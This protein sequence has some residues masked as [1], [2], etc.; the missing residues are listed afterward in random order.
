MRTIWYM[1]AK[2]RLAGDIQTALRRAAPAAESALDLMSGTGVVSQALAARG[3]LRV[4]ANDVQR[5]A[6]AI[7]RAHL[8]HP[9]DP[10][11]VADALDPEA[12]LGRVYRE[13]FAALHAH[14][15]EAVAL[16]DAF[17]LAGG[18]QPETPD[19]EVG[20]LFSAPSDP[21]ALA[22]ARRHVPQRDA[23]E[24]ARAYRA[25]ALHGTPLFQEG[26]ARPADDGFAGAFR[27]AREL[28][29]AA[30]VEARRRDPSLRPWVL[31]SV[32]WP[33]VYL[34][35]RQAI[36]LDSLRAAI[37]SLG[38]REPLAGQKR[39]L[40]LAALL[41]ALSVTT[42]ATSHFCQPRGL[43]SDG[44]VE[45]VQERRAVSLPSRMLAYAREIADAAAQ[46]PRRADHAVFAGDWRGLYARWDEV[47]ADVVYVDPP[48]TADNYS[49]FY[50][51]LEVVTA[52]DYP[53]LQNGGATKGRYPAR[54]TR[55][56]SPFC[57][58]GQV[59]R[60][61]RAVCEETARRGA[62]LVLSYGEEN[63][64]CL[65]RWRETGASPA[66]ARARFGALAE[67][68]YRHVE[69]H[70][71]QLLHSGQGDS[72]HRVTELLLVAR[73]PRAARRKGRTPCA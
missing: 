70:T 10:V 26:A 20:P 59:E 18:R 49:R 51:V 39:D 27:A 19:P 30:T 11:R 32:Y 41:H 3:D 52:Y 73:G 7:A 2:T 28:F 36:A 58:R 55:H 71:R 35:L 48:Y 72:N 53:L 54:E 46:A 23:R 62:A 67:S 21:A 57:V 12:D 69:L 24:R 63:G 66:E 5:Y 4:V 45:A 42:S 17:L 9:V 15:A 22:R 14:L 31:A 16:E 37:A 33:N 40:W 64:L 38:G 29:G 60:E 65:R 68:A 56:R 13:N 6:A 8:V 44:E 25:F 43:G 50:H 1:G 34:G 47:A 61:L